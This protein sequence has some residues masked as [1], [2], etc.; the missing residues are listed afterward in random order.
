MGAINEGVFTSAAA[1]LQG[2]SPSAVI[3]TFAREWR[4]LVGP[5]RFTIRDFRA[6]TGGSSA[7]ASFELTYLN[8]VNGKTTTVPDRLDLRRANGEWRIVPGSAN[9]LSSGSLLTLNF[10]AIALSNPD[11]W[12]KARNIAETM[13]CMVNM[14]KLCDATL[15]LRRDNAGQFPIRLTD[16]R[17][18]VSKYLKPPDVPRCPLDRS[19]GQ[20]YLM[21]QR[22]QGK[23]FHEV[24]IP[25][26]TVMLYEGKAQTLLFRHD[27]RAVVGMADGSVRLVNE[28]QSRTLRWIP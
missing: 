17:A 26:D 16:Y 3:Q 7:Q 23:R 12:P 4:D 10:L 18:S 6:Q 11:A 5:V 25:E 19:S 21:N 14:R 27:R 28:Q 9:S 15:A 13:R 20:S 8:P 22:L 2:G 24:T 1:M